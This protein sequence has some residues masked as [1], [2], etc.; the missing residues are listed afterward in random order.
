MKPYP[1]LKGRL[2][3]S[4]RRSE[5]GSFAHASKP[6]GRP[7]P[8]CSNPPGAR[9]SQIHQNPPPPPPRCCEPP[10]V[11]PKPGRSRHAKSLAST[12]L[13]S[14]ESSFPC[15]EN[16]SIPPSSKSLRSAFPRK[17]ILTADLRLGPR[18]FEG[19]PQMIPSFPATIS[20][21]P[22]GMPKRARLWT[23]RGSLAQKTQ[24]DAPR[25]T[26][27]DQCL[28]FQPSDDPPACSPSPWRASQ[29]QLDSA[30]SRRQARVVTKQTR[31][32]F[33]PR[34]LPK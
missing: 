9:K 25:R 21:A 4:Q 17:R 10:G 19:L 16:S 11:T 6:P 29:G 30:L 1:S 5:N 3:S 27:L 15:P 34:K 24:T 26:G 28:Q 7:P 18:L 13:H 2:G 20:E 22:A 31:A 8:T 12:T 33:E 14:N 32:G 23:T